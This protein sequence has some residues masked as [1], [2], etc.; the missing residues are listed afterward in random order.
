MS[1][2]QSSQ[3]LVYVF[4]TG[5]GLYLSTQNE[6]GKVASFRHGFVSSRPNL[7]P[8]SADLLVEVGVSSDESHSRVYRPISLDGVRPGMQSLYFQAPRLRDSVHTSD[9][10]ATYAGHTVTTFRPGAAHLLIGLGG[11]WWVDATG[12]HWRRLY[13]RGWNGPLQPVDLDLL[14]ATLEH[15]RFLQIAHEASLEGQEA[16][17]KSSPGWARF[18]DEFETTVAESGGHLLAVHRA[19]ATRY[20]PLTRVDDFPIEAG[21][22]E[23]TIFDIEDTFMRAIRAHCEQCGAKDEKVRLVHRPAGQ[24]LHFAQ[25]CRDCAEGAGDGSI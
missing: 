16:F 18:A 24:V 7:L 5:G 9:I 19:P 22:G 23:H 15:P 2:P 8:Y 13:A 10:M 12:A 25:L 6:W 1:H 17:D 21:T 4:R 3:Y 11:A 20:Q 14:L